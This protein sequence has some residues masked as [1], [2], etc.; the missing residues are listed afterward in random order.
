M[1]AAIASPYSSLPFT[2][3][4][5]KLITTTVPTMPATFATIFPTSIQTALFAVLTAS[6]NGTHTIPSRDTMSFV[7]ELVL[8]SIVSLRSRRDQVTDPTPEH[9]LAGYIAWQFAS[10]P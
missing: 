2:P 1:N 4:S 9:D 5:S 7:G 6:D 8:N 3:R 10:S